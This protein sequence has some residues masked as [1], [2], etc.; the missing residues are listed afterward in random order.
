[1]ID[2]AS[3]TSSSGYQPSPVLAEKIRLR[4]RTCVFPYCHR[5]A[6][7]CDLDHVQPY[8]PAGPPGQTSSDN[9]ACLCRLHHRMK[10]HCESGGWTYTMLE[11]GT[12]LWSSPHGHTYLT[13][14]HGTDDLT[15]PEVDRPVDP[16]ER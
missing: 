12:F 1:V 15:P 10:T 11:P 7:L 4:D 3:T 13:Y 2:L 6:R 8:D 16:P 14:A 9:L 5:P